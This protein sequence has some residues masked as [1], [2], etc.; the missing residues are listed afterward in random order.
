MMEIV[1]A[2]ETQVPELFRLWTEFFDYHRD[3]DPY[4]SRTEDARVHIEKRFRE[5]IE[6]E[7]GQVLV[8]VCDGD[9]VGYS[10][11]WVGEGSPFVKQRRYGFICDLAVTSNQR[12]KGIGS[13]LLESTLAWFKAKGIERIAIYTL[14]GNAKAVRFWERQGFKATMQC[15][16]QVIEITDSD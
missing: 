2:K 10:L 16:E 6:S 5:K 9:M 4:Y 13:A 3:I 8:A 14:V 11:F 15:M 7:D 1:E 12:G